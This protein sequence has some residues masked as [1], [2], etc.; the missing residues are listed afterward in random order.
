MLFVVTALDKPGAAAIRAEQRPA[1]LEFLKAHAAAVKAAGPL[2][3]DD[4]QGMIGSLL[5]FEA[6]DRAALDALL[7]RDPYALAGLFETVTVRPWR[8]LIG[9]PG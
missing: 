6:E 2:L 7:A 3:S 4:G 5:V 9:N 1:H 8:W